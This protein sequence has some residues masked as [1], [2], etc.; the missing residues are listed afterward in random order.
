M[1]FDFNPYTWD[2]NSAAIK[3]SVCSFEIN[4]EA[5]GT[6]NV[7]GLDKDIELTI[8]NNNPSNE[9]S[10]EPE[11]SFLKPNKM[12][13]R[14]YYTEIPNASVSINLAG[15]DK[16]MVIEVLV[17]FGSRPTL[18]DFDQNFTVTLTK[19]C[20]GNNTQGKESQIECATEPPISI[21]V[22][23][24][25]PTTIYVGLLSLG[26]KNVS[27]HSRKRRSCF[28]RGR[29]RRSC[30]GV[31][32]PPLEGFNKTVMPTYDSTTDVNY[33]MTMSQSSCLYWSTT[34]EK[35][36]SEGCKVG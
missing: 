35:W 4:S 17:K 27:E 20:Q 24:P 31:K 1:T 33:T 26:E 3:S 28:G 14:S 12:T 21:S 36:T 13:I 2:P 16:E 23:P 22:T 32:D 18:D 6:M 7:S 19:S 5:E 11:S 8:P 10:S 34:K 30:V 15:Q 25:E 9:E 29:Q